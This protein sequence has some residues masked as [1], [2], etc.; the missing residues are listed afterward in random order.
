MPE[1][2]VHADLEA[3]ERALDPATS[4]IVQ[5][6]AGSGKTELLIQRY[7]TLL[8]TVENPEEILAITFTNKA[9]AEMRQRVLLALRDAIEGDEPDADH[10]KLTRRLA[11][12]VLQQD[13]RRGWQLAR[14]AGRLRIQTLDSFNAMLARMEPLTASVSTTGTGIPGD[15][16]LKRLYRDAAAATLEYLGGPEAWSDSVSRVLTHMD[17]NVSQYVER[18]ADMLTSRDQWLPLIGGARF[19]DEESESVRQTLEADLEAMID[20]SLAGISHEL[21]AALEPELLEIARFAA[22]TL[23]SSGG[24]SPIRGLLGIE[25]LPESDWHAIDT[26]RAIA[27]LLLTAQGAPRKQVTK[28]QGFPP[29]EGEGKVMKGRLL[30]LLD[31]LQL[32]SEFLA[33]LHDVRTLPPPRYPDE[34]W[35]VLRALLDLLKLATGEL[36][37]LFRARGATDYIEISLGAAAALGDETNPTELGLLLDYRIEHILVDEVQ[38]TSLAQYHMLERLVAGWTGSDGRTLF[39]VGDPMQSIY[40][41]RNAEVAQFLVAREQGVGD[42]SLEPLTLRQNFRSGSGLVDWFNRTFERVMPDNDDPPSGAVSYAEAVSAPVHEGY[43]DVQIHP[44]LGSAERH[45]AATSV[46]VVAERLA[47]NPDD[48]VVILVRGRTQLRELVPAL[49]DAGIAFNAVDIDTLTELPEV[50]DLLSL[51]RAIAQP[52]D[53]HAWLGVLRAPWIGLSFADLVALVQG[54]RRS[55]VAELLADDERLQRLSSAGREAIER[56]RPWLARL[57]LPVRAGS[58]HERV[59]EAWLNLGGPAW[60]ES[61][62]AAD[63]VHHFF[64][65]LADIEQS[66][67]L[68]D[69]ALLE[70]QLD[71]EKVSSATAD[72]RVEI[73]TMHKSKGLQFDHVVLHG[74]GR[75]TRGDSS[76]V[77][78]WIEST[79]RDGEEHL[80]LAPV[81]RSDSVERDPIHVYLSLLNKQKSR[82]ELQRL[83][84]VACTRAKKSLHLVGHVKADPEAGTL[85]NPPAGSLLSLLWPMVAA[86]FRQ[87]LDRGDSI[88]QEDSETEWLLPELR[89]LSADWQAPTVDYR[90]LLGERPREKTEQLRYEWAGSDAKVTGTLVHRWLQAWTEGRLASCRDDA[91][92]R[93]AVT[94]RW[95]R[96]GGYEDPERVLERVNRAL[97]TLQADERGRWL[98]SGDGHAELVLTGQLDGGVVTGVIDRVRIDGDTHWIVDYKTSDHEGGNRDFFL[99]EEVRRYREQLARY[100]Q[101]Y[102]GWAG[103]RPKAALYFP[104][105]AEFIEVDAL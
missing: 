97:D 104:L 89:R 88:V 79:S 6:P 55:T 77:L 49:R 71:A 68:A 28:T 56:A 41:F 40:R 34:Q 63:N 17:C 44:V 83:L 103:V 26:W 102:E 57:S 50:V 16:E 12:A 5:A 67:T 53:R 93:D 82:F 73:M 31:V 8:S 69:V 7:L 3:R 62:A 39:C 101:L 94:R 48:R 86:D 96:E 25:A 30:E 14:N 1:I 11:Q 51:T 13:A 59:E 29:G 64:R 90:H 4:F 35:Q 70:S 65:V 99:Q 95:L 76:R 46:R 87:A 38:D 80:L 84:Y 21:P 78:N 100:V 10:L 42:Q 19:S 43:G 72:A 15:A 91:G 81:G 9:A 27:E 98:L 20:D 37:R 66:G 36:K 2:S 58:L 105:M 75:T 52:F 18:L 24:T 85:N 61:P 74:L 54:D 92:A 60:L 47:D 33:R 23:E 45:E 22:G 32:D